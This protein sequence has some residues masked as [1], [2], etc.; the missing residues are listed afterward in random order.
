[1][2][3]RYIK[4]NWYNKVGELSSNPYDNDSLYMY[5]E[6]DACLSTLLRVIFFG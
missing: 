3:Q 6:Y 1:M 5:D 2:C 4:R